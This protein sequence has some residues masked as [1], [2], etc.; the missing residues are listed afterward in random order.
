MI[1][2]LRILRHRGHDVI[3]FHVLD[4]AEVSFPFDSLSDLRTRGEPDRGCGGIRSDTEAVAQLRRIQA[5]MSAWAF[6]RA[7]QHAIELCR[8]SPSDKRDSAGLEKRVRG[9]DKISANLSE[10][11]L[12]FTIN[13]TEWD[14]PGALAIGQC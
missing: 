13:S 7:R 6:R 1:D 11:F 14:A 10:L 8:T 9:K 4:E 12:V 5:R 3:V 2:S